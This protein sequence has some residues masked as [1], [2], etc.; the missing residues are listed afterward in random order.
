MNLEVLYETET[1]SLVKLLGENI[2][3]WDLLIINMTWEW[4]LLE[5][6][7]DPSEFLPGHFFHEA[8]LNHF[9]QIGKAMGNIF[10]IKGG[11]SSWG[12]SRESVSNESRSIHFVTVHS[13]HYERRLV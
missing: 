6:D 12:F 7:R 1:R 5:E 2:R 13:K 9:L 3:I 4:E 8:V 11:S 10:E